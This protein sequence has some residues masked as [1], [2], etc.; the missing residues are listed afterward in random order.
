MK[1]LKTKAPGLSRGTSL[2]LHTHPITTTTT[3]A[4]S[5]SHTT[6]ICS[7]SFLICTTHNTKHTN[8]AAGMY[9][10]GSA[11][12]FQLIKQQQP[13]Q[14]GAAA[15]AADA[16]QQLL[17]RSQPGVLRSTW[18]QQ[19]QQL[20]VRSLQTWSG[21]TPVGMLGSGLGGAS[22]HLQPQQRVRIRMGVCVCVSQPQ[23]LARADA[24]SA[25][26]LQP[27]THTTCPVVAVL[28]QLHVR[29]WEAFR[30]GM[31]GEKP[32][33]VCTVAAVVCVSALVAR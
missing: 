25:C 10:R 33:G 29:L 3:H 22:R 17:F 8:Q 13:A 28:L 21:K 1:I 4:P 32:Q 2:L 26:A 20:R 23:V 30:R 5:S 19:H 7:R 12:L 18:L 6:S 11:R 31:S 15:A 9:R 27:H 16:A 24:Q 14:T